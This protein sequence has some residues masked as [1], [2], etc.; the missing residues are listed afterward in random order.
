[1]NLN[2]FLNKFFFIGITTHE[3]SHMLAC[4]LLGV[5][6]K[7]FKLIG[8][9]GGYVVHEAS[10]NYKNILISMAPFFINLLLAIIISIVIK[11]IE[12]KIIFIVILVWIAISSLFF[13]VPSKQDSK[14]VYSSIKNSYTKKQSIVSWIFKILIFPITLIL[15]ILAWLFEVLDQSFIFRF[16]LIIGW[17]YIT[18]II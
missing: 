10:R 5:K 14:N 9:S 1:M 17:V 2:N 12:L 13:S 16:F 8:S 6:I 18:I 11:R 4:L 15:L 3:L 7:K